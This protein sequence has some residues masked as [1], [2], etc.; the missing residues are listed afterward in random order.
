MNDRDE[1]D[2]KLERLVDSA[3]RELPLRR[4]PLNL[5]SRVFEELARCAVMPWWQ[6]SFMQWPRAARVLLL[7]ICSVLGGLTIVGGARIV[8]NVGPAL[9]PAPEL[10]RALAL[11]SASKNLVATLVGTIPPMWIYEGLAL[12]AI[13]YAALFALGAAA[14]RTLYLEA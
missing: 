1:A 13:L 8:V 6:R 2:L 9:R 12:A 11:L 10:D 14:Y 3:L 4:A 7:G 5:E